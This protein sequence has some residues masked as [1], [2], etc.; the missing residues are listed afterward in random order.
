MNK[1]ATTDIAGETRMTARPQK[2]VTH[3][4][5]DNEA[6]EAANFYTSLFTKSRIVN[7]TRYSDAAAKASGRPKGSVMN[8]TFEL[9]GQEFIALNGGPVFKFNPSVSFILN[10]DPSK[11]ERAHENLDALWGKL[12]KGGKVLM[13]LDKYPFSQ[14]YGWL[15]DKYGL[16]WQLILSDPQAEERPFITPS[17]MFVGSVCG[18][19]EE[20]TDLYLSLFKNSR[21]GNTARYPKG[22]EPD[23]EGTITFTDFLLGNQWLAA[24]D[25]AHEH[26]FQFNEA[27]SL[28]VHCDTQK[29][30]DD[31]WEKLTEGGGQPGVC[32]WLKDKY[33]LSWQIVP[34][35]LR[36]MMTDKDTKKSERVMEALLKMTKLDVEALTDAYQKR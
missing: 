24:M 26:K 8:V 7:T 16:S 18:K 3:L 30:V 21:R 5:F 28:M 15:Q 11:D 17:L 27:I 1:Q 12:S 2:I 23:K 36:D 13:P 33:G 6:E 22:M 20:A 34:A 19:A 25:S 29:E 4:W 32:G 9:D 10:F 14:H 31:L 35:A